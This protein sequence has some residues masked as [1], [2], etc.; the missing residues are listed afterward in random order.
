MW[1]ARRKSRPVA[2]AE[3]YHLLRDLDPEILPG[4]PLSEAKGVFWI[5]LPEELLDTARG[6]LPRLG[7]TQAVDLPV[8]LAD[9]ELPSNTKKALAQ[10]QLI[11]WQRQ[12]YQPHRIYEASRE[13][14]RESAP[15]RRDFMLPAPGGDIQ[16]VRGYRGDGKALSRRGLPPHDARMLVNLVRPDQPQGAVFLDPFAGV[17][18]VLLEAKAAGLQVLSADIDPFLMY[19]LSHFRS[20]HCVADAC[21]LPFSP[22]T[23][24]AI[25]AEPPYDRE[26]DE[27][28]R[29]SLPEMARVLKSGSRL[30][31]FCAAW[32]VESLRQVGQSLNLEK[33]LDAPVNRKGT[34]C[35]VL[36]WVKG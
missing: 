21:A 20:A 5:S 15:D 24:D 13:V 23:I 2:E 36:A 8:A 19:G 31:L 11:R 35:A 34:D 12:Y 29:R 17:G 25:A 3:A 14:M 26:A 9:H 7:Y 30:A 4:G 27:I 33:Y 1:R 16:P 32:Q 18:G 6:R 22:E 10:G 28:V